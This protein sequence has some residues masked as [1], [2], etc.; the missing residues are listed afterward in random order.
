MINLLAG[1]F[2]WTVF[3]TPA[4]DISD[5]IN[6]TLTLFLAEVAFLFVI[7]DKLPQV[8][9][10]TVMDRIILGSFVLLFFTAVESVAAYMFVAEGTFFSSAAGPNFAAAKKVDMY[11]A[12]LFPLAFILLHF[13]A[14]RNALKFRK[15]LKKMGPSAID[16]MKD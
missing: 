14:V 12:A 13:V 9:Y 3:I 10:L 7:A 6:S 15:T 1:M 2:S 5:R 11:A 8:S 4:S 16:L